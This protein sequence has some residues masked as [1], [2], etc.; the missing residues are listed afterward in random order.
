MYI[1]LQNYLST[2]EIGFFHISILLKLYSPS[3][4]QVFNFIDIGDRLEMLFV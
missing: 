1:C 3:E 4:S 2:K